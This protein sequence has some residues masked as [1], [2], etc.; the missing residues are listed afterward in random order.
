MN[1]VDVRADKP[2]SRPVR[3]GLVIAMIAFLGGIALVSWAITSWDPARELLVGPAQVEKPD[4]LALS[5]AR[6]LVPSSP[7]LLPTP[8]EQRVAALEAKLALMSETNGSPLGDSRRAEGLLLA[9]AARRAIDR[10]LALGYLEAELQNYFGESQPR[11]VG[12]VISAARNPATLAMLKTELDR[13]AP[14]LAEKPVDENFFESARRELA[15]L[16]VVRKAGTPSALA[17]DRIT[18][19]QDLVS[20]GRI[21]QALAEVSRLESRDKAATWMA[22]ARRNIE[23]SAALD[24]LEAAALVAP[25]DAAAQK[26]AALPA[27]EEGPA[28]PEQV[29]APVAPSTT[30]L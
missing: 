19:A 3:N 27:P 15:G 18:L 8:I 17:K 6:P 12:Q 11:A 1:E 20:I 2:Q 30:R 23:A 29:P 22:M 13:V 9:F 26:P 25:R 14:A 4:A 24:I 21:D 7:T 5:D 10:G 28:D 16:F